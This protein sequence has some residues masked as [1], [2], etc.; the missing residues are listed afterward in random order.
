[1]SCLR[2]CFDEHRDILR[3]T[4]LHFSC[5]KVSLDLLRGEN[6]FIG[7]TNVVK[8]MKLSFFCCCRLSD[9]GNTRIKV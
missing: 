1:M 6:D 7:C 8:F 3:I 5:L 9:D 4:L 2:M